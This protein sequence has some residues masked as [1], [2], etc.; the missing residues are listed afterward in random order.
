MNN[1]EKAVFVDYI[2]RNLLTQSN[3]EIKSAMFL[4][5]GY[6]SNYKVCAPSNHNVSYDLAPNIDDDGAQ[7]S[8]ALLSQVVPNIAQGVFNTQ[9]ATLFAFD[10]SEDDGCPQGVRE[11]SIQHMTNP[12]PHVFRVQ[13][14]ETERDGMSV[15]KSKKNLL[16]VVLYDKTGLPITLSHMIS[17][18]SLI[19]PSPQVAPSFGST[20]P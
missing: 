16:D 10:L 4:K 3:P 9:N 13:L 7:A 5:F 19:P 20:G 11:D 17:Q 18:T 12:S 1:F 14:Y 8:Q 2:T 15:S 6:H